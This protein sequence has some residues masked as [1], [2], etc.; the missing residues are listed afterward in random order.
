MCP[1]SAHKLLSLR[2]SRR[3]LSDVQGFYGSALDLRQSPSVY[4]CF[5]NLR[6]L[7]RTTREAGELSC[8]RFSREAISL[9][10]H[11]SLSLSLS[12]FLP[13]NLSRFLSPSLSPSLSLSLSLGGHVWNH[14]VSQKAGQNG[15]KDKCNARSAK[16]GER[17]RRQRENINNYVQCLQLEELSPESESTSAPRL[18]F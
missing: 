3:P 15:K 2:E 10:L 12:L 1:A 13:P 18:Q 11:F 16:R 17:G 6:R 8:V 4:G 5:L 9:P 7:G 14:L